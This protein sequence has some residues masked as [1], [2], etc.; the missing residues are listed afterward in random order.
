MV[1]GSTVAATT[2]AATASAMASSTC[3]GTPD[4][5]VETAFV[6]STAMPVMIVV[7]PTAVIASDVEK[8]IAVAVAVVPSGPIVVV[9]R[10]GRAF[11]VQVLGCTAKKG[12]ASKN[13]S[14]ARQRTNNL[15][16]TGLTNI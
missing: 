5:A 1:T 3:F 15:S 11:V 16:H 7:P 12:H 4:S 6:V 13:Q 14:D 8:A 10:R 2:M 9:T